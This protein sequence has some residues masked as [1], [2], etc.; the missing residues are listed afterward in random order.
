MTEPEIYQTL[1]EIFQDFFLDDSI[2]LTPAT[3]AEDIDGWDS[4]NHINLVVA[5]ESRFGVRFSSAEIE[6]LRN[7]GDFVSLIK[8]KTG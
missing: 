1:T 6:G 5:A 2:A 3:T 8:E 7:V 4:L